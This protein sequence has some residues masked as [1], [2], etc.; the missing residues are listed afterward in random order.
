MVKGL[1]IDD[2]EL[3]EDGMRQQ[4]LTF[5]AEEIT[6][7]AAPVTTTSTLSG[8][9]TTLAPPRPGAPTPTIAARRDDGDAPVPLTSNVAGIGC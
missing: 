9:A 7:S 3:L 6:T 8:A 2:F 4:V 1:K 5:A